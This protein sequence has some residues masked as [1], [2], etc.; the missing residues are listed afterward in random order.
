M[1]MI[2]NGAGSPMVS[3]VMPR[4][5]LNVSVSS[6]AARTSEKR[7]SAQNPKRSLW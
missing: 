5:E 7:L 1:I 4:A 3:R 2:G 6:D